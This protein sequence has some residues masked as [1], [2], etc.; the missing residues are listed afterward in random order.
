MMSKPGC[1]ADLQQLHT[2]SEYAHPSLSTDILIQIQTFLDPDN[3]ISLCKVSIILFSECLIL[4]VSLSFLFETSRVL[5]SITKLQI[6]WI[7][8]LHQVCLM[9]SINLSMFYPLENISQIELEHAA[10]SPFRFIKCAKDNIA[11]EGDI[12]SIKTRFLEP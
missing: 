10:L 3:I 9:H 4:M 6:M 7:D 2:T 11:S 1:A 5:C 8:A 12:K